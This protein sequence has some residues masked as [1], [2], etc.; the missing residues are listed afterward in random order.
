METTEKI[1]ECYVRYVLRWATIPNI[2]CD[3]QYEID[4]IAIDPLNCEKYHIESIESNHSHCENAL[5]HACERV[6]A[7]LP[8]Y[9]DWTKPLHINELAVPPAMG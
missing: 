6:L 2:K 7:R 3:G 5:L 4:L 1:I 9:A 8:L